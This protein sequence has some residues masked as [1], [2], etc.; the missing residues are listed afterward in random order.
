MTVLVNNLKR[1]FRKKANIIVMFVLPIAF[2]AVLSAINGSSSGITVGVVDNDNTKLTQMIKDKLKA[3][4]NEIE[5]IKKDKI[6]KG[7]INKEIDTALIIPKGLT[8]DIINGK[9]HDKIKMYGIKG[10]TNDSS[11]K[12]FINSFTSAAA[13]IGSAAK[14]DSDKFYQGIKDYNN[15]SF[16]SEVRYTD[17]KRDQEQNSSTSVGFLV[18]GVIYLSTMVT[19]LILEDKK[20]GVHKRMFQSGLSSKSYMLQCIGSFVVVNFIQITGVLLIMK[21]ALGLDLGPSPVSL[22]IVLFLFGI[23]CT[24]LGVAISSLCKDLRQANALSM[25]ISTPIAMLGGCYWPRDV[26]GTT[27]E[28]ISNFVP[29][30]WALQAANKIIDGKSLANV[31][32]EMGVIVIF[33]LVFFIIAAAKRVDAAK[34]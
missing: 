10:V 5:I 30:T 14:G 24:A 6:D 28:Q 13:N 2:I 15:G 34:A 29:T 12:Y 11:V 18:M 21:Y 33:I 22:F 31:T 4:G 26:M 7:L 25:L 32:V 23:S 17:G 1:I 27:L 16:S 20:L 3:N 9:S 8:D 19:T